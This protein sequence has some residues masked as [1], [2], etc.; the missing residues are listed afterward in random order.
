V[1]AQSQ[2][3]SESTQQIPNQRLLLKS[4]PTTPLARHTTHIAKRDTVP[5]R[6]E[7]GDGRNQQ[8]Y[9]PHHPFLVLP[10]NF[11]Q[12]FEVAVTVLL[13]YPMV[14]R[15]IAVVVDMYRDADFFPNESIRR[16]R[17]VSLIDCDVLQI[18]KL[19]LEYL[20]PFWRIPSETLLE[21]E[22]VLA[23][24]Y[25]KGLWLN[26]LV[27]WLRSKIAQAVG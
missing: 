2:P 9:L 11:H 4:I 25:W 19:L 6:P 12:L 15:Y 22:D 21:I 13:C 26:L 3:F 10:D 17:T 1:L 23:V 5:A 18:L 20:R 27:G 24:E 14:D 8:V 16:V 7:E